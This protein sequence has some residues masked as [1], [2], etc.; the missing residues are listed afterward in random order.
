MPV[1]NWACLNR[2][3]RL[4][5]VSEKD[6][7]E[8]PGC[9]GTI[10]KWIPKNINVGGKL[11]DDSGERATAAEIAK[12][13]KELGDTYGLNIRPPEL[14]QSQHIYNEWNKQRTVPV[15]M[16]GQP[17]Q[18]PERSVINKEITVS[19]GGNV[20]LLGGP[21]EPQPTEIIG[22]GKSKAK[23]RQHLDWLKNNRKQGK[24]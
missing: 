12:I 17:V 8:C 16:N 18:V 23:F 7:P 11:L 15:M 3:C 9:G 2:R 24:I 22:E 10:L 14:G 5:F 6:T 4:E 19:W 20:P 13:T 21:N 1:R